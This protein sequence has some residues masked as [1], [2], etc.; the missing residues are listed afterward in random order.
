MITS[1]KGLGEDLVNFLLL[2]FLSNRFFDLFV[3]CGAFVLC[4]L[5][6]VCVWRIL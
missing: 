3:S 2:S 5:A 4:S 6:L 1:D